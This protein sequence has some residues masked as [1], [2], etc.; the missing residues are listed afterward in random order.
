MHSCPSSIGGCGRLENNID[1]THP[2]MYTSVQI[3]AVGGASW[4]K[5]VSTEKNGNLKNFKNTVESE[6]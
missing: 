5:G 3:V 2:Y 6:Q 4:K 1:S